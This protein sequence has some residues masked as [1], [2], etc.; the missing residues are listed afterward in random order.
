M[1]RSR[2]ST[3][4]SSDPA[5]LKSAFQLIAKTKMLWILVEC[6]VRMCLLYNNTNLTSNSVTEDLRNQFALVQEEIGQ[7]MAQYRT[8]RIHT[9]QLDGTLSVQI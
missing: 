2:H 1:L 3:D 9:R 4:R 6:F 5:A 7:F 8:V